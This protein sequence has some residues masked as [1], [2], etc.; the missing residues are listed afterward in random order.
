MADEAKAGLEPA[1]AARALHYEELVYPVSAESLGFGTTAE[2]AV[3]GDWFGQERALAALEMG[4]RVRH[5]GFNI[6]VCGLSGTHRQQ[7][8]AALLRRFT[9]GQ[10]TPGDRVLV[11]SFRNPDR[12]R[13]IYLPAGQGVRLRQD[14]RELVEEC[15]RILPETFRKETFEEE[16]E[17]LS[18]KFGEQ[19][20]KVNR[21]LAEQAERA[22]FVIQAAPS[23]EIAF[24][25]LKE[26]RP[27]E[28]AELQ[29]LGDEEKA[30]LRKR[31]RELARQVNA[32]M[33]THR[34]LLRKLGREVKQ[35][36]RRV[37][38]Q[39]ITP[40]VD[41][42][43]ERYQ[44]Q[45]EVKQYL[46]EVR[47]HILDNLSAFQEQSPT[48]TPFPFMAMPAEEKSLLDYEVNVLV[49]NSNGDGP[50][51]LVEASPTYKN[52]FG[53]VERMVDRFGKLVTNFTRVVGGSLL[54]AHGGCVIINVMDALSEPLVYR[55][56]KQCLKTGE[57]E[58]E[59]YDPFAL[60]ATSTL[61]P[62]P[63]AIDTR[64]VL[65]GPADVFQILYFVDEEFR[66]IFKMRCDFGFEADH[67]ENAR[68]NF[69]RQVA[70]IA[71]D[72]GLPPFAAGAVAGL[73]EFAART[74]DD[75]RKL[76]SQWSAVAD[77]MREAAFWAGKNG[78]DG[79][80]LEDVRQAVEQRVFRLNRVEAKIRE[81][82][83][84]GIILVDTDGRRPGQVNGLAVLDIGGYA[85]GRPSRITASVAM[86]AHGVVAVDREA[87]MSGRT[88]DK[89]VFILSG[90]LRHKYA[91]S[92]PLNLSASISLEQSYAEIEGDSA[93]AAELFALISSLSGVPL[94]QDLAVTGSVN[95]FGDIQ[96]IGGVNE[97]IEGFFS[98]CKETSLTGKQGVVIPHQNVANLVLRRD[99]VE[100][101]REG[102]FHIHPI[103]SIDE[104]LEV[105]T[106]VR[107][108]GVEEE[109]TIHGRAV[110]R[111]RQL[112]KGLR[113]F[114]APRPSNTP[115]PQH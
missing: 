100:A 83:R 59:A 57:L 1:P 25:P 63:M 112:A 14:M 97:K 40:L 81:L 61:K 55:A 73:L 75:R 104:G 20:E 66:E 12:P 38:E 47:E 32:M 54:K 80:A 85:F 95:Q 90:Y 4:L 56:L 106:G 86:G 16:K 39:A 99:V 82:I 35:A 108:G 58:I 113:R 37:A 21:E 91:Q 24:I 71:R 26:G 64:V 5:A 18:E 98:V 11:Q 74:V 41:D 114:G 69:V 49:D 42:L 9:E 29:A 33:R 78:R 101:V 6:Y 79:V 13:A 15:R 43:Q 44:N 52:L 36:E 53:A 96:P 60:F 65:T 27:M 23:G 34:S 84:D 70:R 94:R 31:Q 103:R 67:D 46:G 105:L 28:P 68:S 3:D 72:E 93:S 109:N 45:E 10:P 76:P 51:L 87:K 8:L 22:G 92:F 48:P 7:E 115:A 2:V 89:A 88:Y 19:G 102:R 17:R 30:D 111:L 62:E 77:M 50:P 110:Q 107:A